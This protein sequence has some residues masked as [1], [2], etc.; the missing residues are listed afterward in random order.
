[1]T[2]NLTARSYT[3]LGYAVDVTG[4]TKTD[5]INRALQVYAA[6]LKD[7]AEGRRVATLDSDG[8][9][10]FFDADWLKKDRKDVTEP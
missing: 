7:V 5:T 4:D 1:M 6:L 2:V 10:R 9:G 8:N 3:A